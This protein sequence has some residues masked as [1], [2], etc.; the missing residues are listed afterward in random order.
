[1]PD[2]PPDPKR[3]D[4]QDK[5]LDALRATVTAQGTSI[6]TLETRWTIVAA[7][8]GFVAIVAVSAVNGMLT[9]RDAVQATTLRIAAL[10]RA[11][12]D[13]A[14]SAHER[15]ADDRRTTEALVR[16]TVTVESLRAQVADLTSELRARETAP[17]R[18]V[19]R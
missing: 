2:T 1:M 7:I 15:D 10:E 18:P 3:D 19:G 4:A 16:L 6:T 5:A 11:Q 14:A 8:V 17:M 9:A 12:T 13:A